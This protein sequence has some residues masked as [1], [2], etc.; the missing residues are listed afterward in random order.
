MSLPEPENQLTLNVS[1][2]KCTVHALFW[3]EI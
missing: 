2:Q 1:P 3:S